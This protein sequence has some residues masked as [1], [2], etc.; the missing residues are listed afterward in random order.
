[1]GCLCWLLTPW[2][3]MLQQNESYFHNLHMNWGYHAP[4]TFCEA[5]SVKFRCVIGSTHCIVLENILLGR[6]QTWFS[7]KN[8]C[9]YFTFYNLQM[10]SIWQI[11]SFD[12]C[13]FYFQKKKIRNINK[14][15]PTT[16]KNKFLPVWF[17]WNLGEDILKESLKK[18]SLVHCL[19]I[20]NTSLFIMSLFF[21]NE[22]WVSFWRKIFFFFFTADD[23]GNYI[24]ISTENTELAHKV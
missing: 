7:K 3:K 5:R 18:R 24:L 16:G 23:V 8:Y 13:H 14:T 10:N 11:F 22:K 4:G 17:S 15:L 6:S 9:Q 12:H 1:M 20:F 2:S 19:S 21:Q